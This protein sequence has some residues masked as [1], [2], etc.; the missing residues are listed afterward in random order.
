MK[1]RFTIVVGIILLFIVV[2]GIILQNSAGKIQIQ[3]RSD[4]FPMTV[5]SAMLEIAILNA[6]GSSIE[7]AIVQVT[8]QLT[9][10]GAPAISYYPNQVIDGLYQVPVVWS[11]M[12]QG[13]VTVS[14][15]LPDQGGIIEEIFS[16]F[17]YL[18]P[19]LNTNNQTTYRSFDEINH[20]VSVNAST[21][22]WIVIPQ[23][24]REMM[25]MGEGDEFVP[26][27]IRLKL[28][29]QNTLVIR[30]DD[31]A[32]HT[33]GPFFVR[34]GETVRQEF[35]QTAILEGSCS[36]R[37]GASIKIIVEQS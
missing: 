13:S 28:N 12:G 31:F 30:N 33:V 36:I 29:G 21:E 16:V 34:A 9:K 3:L 7:D 8:T 6:D 15:E 24:T 27:Q 5:G 32:D 1:T 10:P 17:I 20:D 19:P 4:P 14:A 18:V 2:A 11:M 26:A 35:T 23:G 25:L 22:Y 37:H